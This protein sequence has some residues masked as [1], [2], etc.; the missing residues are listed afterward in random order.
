MRASK[1]SKANRTT[2]RIVLVSKSKKG[3]YAMR[4][5]LKI[6]VGLAL[7]ACFITGGLATSQAQ[8][9]LTIT[10]ARAAADGTSVTVHG[11]VNVAPGAFDGQNKRFYIQDA[12]SG[13]AIYF[14]DGGLPA[15]VEGDQ[16]TVSGTMTTFKSERELQPA[17][18][19]A[20]IK[21]G[22]N[23]SPLPLAIKTGELGDK[24]QGRLISFSGKVVDLKNGFA[25]DDGSGAA[26][27]FIYKTTGISQTPVVGQTVTVIGIAAI[28]GGAFE[29]LPRKA[30]DIKISGVVNPT[31]TPS[32]TQRVRGPLPPPY[33]LDRD[34]QDVALEIAAVYAATDENAINEQG[35]AVQLFNSADSARDL[36]G[37]ALSDNVHSVKLDGVTIAAHQTLWLAK[38]A[39]R[40][41]AE[42]NQT[43]AAEYGDSCSKAVPCLTGTPL[44]FDNQGGDV[45]LSSP[46]GVVDVLVYGDGYS[47]VPGWTGAAVQPYRFADYVPAAGQIFYRKLD[48]TTGNCL[49][50]TKNN[51]QSTD[52]AQD[53]T[54]PNGGRRLLFP[55]WSTQFCDTA[56]GI[57]NATTTFLVAPDNSLAGLL[58]ALDKAKTE[59]DLELYFLTSPGIVDH[60][61]AAQSRGVNVR[62]LFD[63]DLKPGDKTV[64]LPGG[65]ADAYLQTYWAAQEITAHGGKAF[66][67]AADTAIQPPIPHRYNDDHQKF[68]IIDG[69]TSV[70]SSENFAQTAFPAVTGNSTSGNRGALV[71]T[72]SPT[73]TR[74]LAAIFENDVSHSDIHPW[75][76][77][78]DHFNQ[79]VDAPVS[80]NYTII[81]PQPLTI[82]GSTSFEVVNAPDNA[83]NTADALIGMVAKAGKGDRVLVEQQYEY[84]DW[85]SPFSYMNP[86]LTAYIDAARR[87]AKVQIILDGVNSASTNQPTL[88]ALKKLATAESLALDVHITPKTGVSGNAF[89]IKMV[90]ITSGADGFVHIGSIN[91][92]ENSS[93]YNREVAVQVESRAAFD[94]YAKVF[95][96]DWQVVH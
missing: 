10:Q 18:L 26:H 61:T 15:L 80:T 78:S 23:D 22:H 62:A 5:F 45:Y 35:E 25:L 75:A 41:T 37:W 46:T 32:D 71:I 50:G 1:Y 73:V 77:V 28:Y 48:L 72:D 93:R 20:V 58:A 9:M 67:W 63:G 24:Q 8:T 54:D 68:V 21:A 6:V 53:P 49:P 83:V 82:S 33:A 40:F 29:V 39:V 30:S 19:T 4:R 52:W 91:G 36:T 17:A 38:N 70:I 76:N 57:D 86:R 34:P 42:F 31:A 64:L 13:L 43:P 90:I 14:N 3:I 51:H 92:S 59:I 56:K 81:Q 74:R 11:L 95:D 47:T 60:V 2:I 16:V 65:P 27:V 85:G 88:I 84:L 94:Y 55:G 79:P 96:A 44:A 12:V 89:H 87:G 7:T 66:F 69:T